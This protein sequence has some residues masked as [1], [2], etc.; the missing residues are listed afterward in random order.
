MF[1][2]LY[3]DSSFTICNNYLVP[4]QQR[5]WT[6]SVKN[7]EICSEKEDVSIPT[8]QLNVPNTE[9]GK[10]YSNSNVVLKNLIRFQVSRSM[11]M[12]M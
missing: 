12:C 8:I 4:L 3:N 11:R 6:G 1:I 5:L 2:Y 9:S 10:L 7:I